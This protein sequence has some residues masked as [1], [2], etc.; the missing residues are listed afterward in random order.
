MIDIVQRDDIDVVVSDITMRNERRRAGQRLLES[1]PQLPVI[2]SPPSARWTSR[3][4]IRAGAYD[5]V[6]PFEIDQ[7]VLA[8][9]RA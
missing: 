6:L 2:S 3:Q 8:I 4:A 9:D 1:R 5:F 7:L